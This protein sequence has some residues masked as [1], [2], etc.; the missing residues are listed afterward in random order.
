MTASRV[1]VPTWQ[2]TL[3]TGI[4]ALVAAL[5][6]SS[7]NPP[8]A[9]AMIVQDSDTRVRSNHVGWVY[10]DGLPF[11]MCAERRVD[12]PPCPI[13]VHDTW[14]WNGSRWLPSSIGGGVQVYAYP[15]AGSWH[16]IWTRAGGWVA[17]PTSD[18]RLSQTWN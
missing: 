5:V 6:I 15:F 2:R 7:L 1:R 11:P 3:F 10:T 13:P 18:L 14:R 17:I 16:W 9:P 4:V 8:E 12:D